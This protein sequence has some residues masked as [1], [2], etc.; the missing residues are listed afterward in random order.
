ML[1]SNGKKIR[2]LLTIT[3]LLILLSVIIKYNYDKD[4]LSRIR[5][6]IYTMAHG[7]PDYSNVR[8]GELGKRLDDMAELT[9]RLTDVTSLERGGD[10][11]FSESFE[12]G[13]KR[14]YSSLYGN[15]ASFELNA[16]YYVSK[17]FSSKLVAGSTGEAQGTISTELPYL[18]ISNFGFESRL[19]FGN[20]VQALAFYIDVYDGETQYTPKVYYWPDY[21]KIY[22]VDEDDVLRMVAEDVILPPYGY[23]FC[24]IKVTVDYTDKKYKR[25]MF[26]D[27]T[28]PLTEYG[29]PSTPND[30]SPRMVPVISIISNTGKNGEIYVDNVFVT[31]NEP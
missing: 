9:A 16:D 28:V 15:G 23:T 30:S 24:F 29:I 2:N 19:K 8:K 31:R 6:E 14:W 17:G 10:V 20:E 18:D 12:H 25:L 26:N 3:L 11:V 5:R 7:A 27:I 1:P 22:I 21:K 4:N 13:L